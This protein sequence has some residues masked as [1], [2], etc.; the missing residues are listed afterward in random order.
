MKHPP[1]NPGD[2]TA[3]TA[4]EKRTQVVALRRQRLTFAQIGA[5]MGFTPQRAHQLYIQA[6]KSVPVL[7]VTQHRAEQLA[8]IDEAISHLLPLAKTG[9]VEH[10][11][12]AWNAIRGWAEREA[13]LLGTD[14]ET[15]V[16][17][18]GG[19]TYEIVGVPVDQL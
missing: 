3:I 8:L 12:S 7:E 19:V 16:S 6:L 9:P 14:S 4:A 11:V 2:D 15:K 10:R 18:S 13:K 17:L 1:H 5:R